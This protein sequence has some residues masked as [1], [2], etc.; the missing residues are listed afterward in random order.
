MFCVAGLGNP[1]G[2]YT[3]T[4]H[5][6]GF[7]VVDRLAEAGSTRIRRREF[8]AL[9]ATIRIDRT[10]VLL[11]KPQTYMNRCGRSLEVACR[12]LGIPSER[13]IVVVDDA[14]LPAGRVRIRRGGG[15]GGH[16][17][18]ASIIE[19]TGSRDFARVRLGIG[20]PPAGVELADYVLG[21]LEEQERAALDELVARGAEAVT[22]IITD[23]LEAAMQA[24]NAA[25]VTPVETWKEE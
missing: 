10:E 19:E 2:K 20:R 23:G 14:D 21:D 6:I 11:M 13:V 8:L 9:T 1:G 5:N 18:I 3:S 12:T 24:F 25:P 22:E 16:R 17:G 4:R 7:R 15:T